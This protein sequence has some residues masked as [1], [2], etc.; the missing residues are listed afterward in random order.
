MKADLKELYGNRLQIDTFGACGRD[1]T[2]NEIMRRARETLGKVSCAGIIVE[3]RCSPLHNCC[4]SIILDLNASISSKLNCLKR[5]K[6]II[7]TLT[8]VAYSN[9]LHRRQFSFSFLLRHVYLILVLYSESEWYG[10]RNS[11]H[12]H[13][14]RD[15]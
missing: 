4:Y 8:L 2:Y 10:D 1:L 12:S 9:F 11:V 5:V 7:Q 13:P 3:M 6:M 14:D 15:Y